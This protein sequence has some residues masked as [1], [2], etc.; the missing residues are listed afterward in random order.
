MV[1]MTEERDEEFEDT[2]DS[3]TRQ[4]K[5]LRMPSVAGIVVVAASSFHRTS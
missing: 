1:T 2:G 4:Q 5:C 3:I